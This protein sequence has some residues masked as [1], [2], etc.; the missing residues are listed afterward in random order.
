MKKQIPF[1]VTAVLLSALFAQ[2]A[3]ANDNAEIFKKLDVDG[4]GLITRQEAEANTDLAGSFDDGD[5]NDDGVLDLAE[6][7]KME[8]TDE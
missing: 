6:F 4:N 1:V 8:V 3:S 2:S 7:S 5:D